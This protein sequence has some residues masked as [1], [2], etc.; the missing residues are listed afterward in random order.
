MAQVVVKSLHLY[1]SKSHKEC[2][3]ST[4]NN[5]FES[6]I[7]NERCT[8]PVGLAQFLVSYRVSAQLPGR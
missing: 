4:K 7:D 8:E 1:V 5:Q 3:G 2:F 6:G